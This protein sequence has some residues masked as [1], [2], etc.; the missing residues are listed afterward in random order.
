MKAC[1]YCGEIGHF[2]RDCPKNKEIRKQGA[3]K[4]RII[5]SRSPYPEHVPPSDDNVSDLELYKE[6]RMLN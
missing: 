4:I 2:Y 3:I 6:A 1:L 5:R